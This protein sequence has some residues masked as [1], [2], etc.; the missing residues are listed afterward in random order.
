[1]WETPDLDAGVFEEKRFI[2]THVGN[3]LIHRLL[4]APQ[5]VHPHACGKHAQ[6]PLYFK[7]MCGSSPRM[8][9]TP[10]LVLASKAAMRFIPTHVGNTTYSARRSAAITVHPHA[11]GKH[12]ESGRPLTI[13]DGSSPRMW[14]TQP[15][16]RCGF[17]R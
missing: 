15:V 6:L 7:A 9:E 17:P 8:W 4:I 10:I 13:E 1:M 5:S 11:C 2:P 3:T 12:V 16:I 14:E